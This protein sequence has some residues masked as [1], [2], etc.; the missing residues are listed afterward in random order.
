MTINKFKLSVLQIQNLPNALCGPLVKH[1]TGLSSSFRRQEAKQAKGPHL[2]KALID[3]QKI[4]TNRTTK[5][6]RTQCPIRTV[7]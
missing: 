3:D 6:K 1:M 5:K 7:G 2:Q 4:E